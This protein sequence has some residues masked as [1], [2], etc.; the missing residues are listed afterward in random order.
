MAG[1]LLKILFITYH[2]P[3]PDEAGAGRPWETAAL[4]RELGHEP[5]VVTAGTHYMTGEDIRAKRGTWLSEEQ[6]SGIQVMK[7]YAPAGHRRSLGR[8]L[9]NYVCYA[10]AALLA[11]LRQQQVDLIL[12]ATDPV[13]ILPVGVVLAKLKG[14]VLMLDERDLFPDSMVALG[15]LRSHAVITG[16]EALN[17]AV[18]RRSR[19]ILAA[20]PGIKRMLVAKGNDSSK[21]FF[22]PN[23]RSASLADGIPPMEN[24]VRQRHGWES[25]FLVIYTGN[26]GQ[27]YDIMTALRAAQSLAITAPNVHFLFF[28]DGERKSE[29]LAYCETAGLSNVQFLHA[30]P[31]FELRE[32]LAVANIALH[33]L[34]NNPFWECVL[35]GKIFDYL[36]AAKPIALAGFGDAA[37]L[38]NAAGAGVV[39]KPG[40]SAGLAQNI[41]RLAQSPARAKEMGERGR[42]YVVSHFGRDRLRTIM[43]EAISAAVQNL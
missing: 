37:D 15:L 18:R 29:Y 12:M 35:G 23:L 34:P 26:F 39:S 22:L 40:D 8:R 36:L 10:I 14:A 9:I 21:I 28:G 2:F 11:G 33:V 3:T 43:S 7:T 42:N 27:T 24:D 4:L 41:D 6:I 19:S 31:W 13:F 5:I 20:T 1:A 38:I 16:W 25:K 32:Y 17:R 30:R